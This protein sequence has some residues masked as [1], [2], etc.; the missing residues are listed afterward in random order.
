MVDPV[1]SKMIRS[2]IVIFIIGALV[3]TAW[4]PM[5]LGFLTD[6]WTVLVHP[7]IW[8]APFSPARW[9]ALEIAQNRPVLRVIFFILTSIVPANPVAWHS[10]G[11][12]LN[13]AAAA[14]I[15]ICVRDILLVA[16]Q[17]ATSARWSGA[18]S[19][20]CWL[21]F[22]WSVATSFWATGTTAM[23]AVLCFAVSVSLLVRHWQG[24]SFYALL[25]GAVLS[26]AGYLTYEAFYF[27]VFAVIL[28]LIWTKGWR[29]PASQ[30]AITSYSAAQ[31]AAMAFNQYMRLTGADGARK[32]NTSFVETFFHWYLYVGRALGIPSIAIYAVLIVGAVVIAFALWISRRHF[33]RISALSAIVAGIAVVCAGG[34]VLTLPLAFPETIL[35]TLA[36]ISLVAYINIVP[37]ATADAPSLAPIYLL[38]LV[39]AA[40]G[41]LPFSLGNYVVFSL[42]FGARA[43]LASSFWMALALGASAGAAIDSGNLKRRGSLA[44]GGIALIWL[45]LV[46]GDGLRAREWGSAARLLE[47]VFRDPPDFPFAQ[48][49][50]GATFILVG[51]EQAGWVPVIEVNHHVSAIAQIAFLPQAKTPDQI[52]ALKAWDGH[53]IVAR[54][55]IWSTKWDGAHLKQTLCKD[56]T[57]FTAIDVSEL[58]VWDTRKREIAKAGSPLS[59]GCAAVALH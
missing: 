58:W 40:L 2:P 10:V 50:P 14:A 5:V 4:H 18:V 24:G 38:A 15:A 33:A 16:G 32:I 19:G 35:L 49:A 31:F 55:Q 41:A 8:T 47:T 46:A 25:G 45:G 11:A 27:Q 28:Y 3:A 12:L 54:N 30:V 22:P 36:G 56:G 53:W 34:V 42:G 23:P 7:T 52:A 13:I 51:P 59:L 9:D 26:L 43:T 17:R 6:D 57:V 37:P 44:V 39:G 20:L 21:A 48:A 1:S 29:A